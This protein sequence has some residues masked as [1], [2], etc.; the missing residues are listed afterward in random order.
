MAGPARGS[1]IYSS[2]RSRA[3]ARSTAT[4]LSGLL[5]TLSI[6]PVTVIPAGRAHRAGDSLDWPTP[7]PSPAPAVYRPDGGDDRSCPPP[8]LLVEPSAGLY[9][10]PRPSRPPPPPLFHDHSKSVR[11]TGHG[12]P[13]E[14]LPNPATGPAGRSVSLPLRAR[15]PLQVYVG[16]PASPSD[17]SSQRDARAPD[18]NSRDGGEFVLK[19]RLKTNRGHG[20]G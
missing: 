6:T 17:L 7:S 10:R 5:A 3:P 12:R 18:G 19:T 1:N 11:S 8:V 16:R 20:A 2:F 4:G 9:L 14:R 13:R 15:A